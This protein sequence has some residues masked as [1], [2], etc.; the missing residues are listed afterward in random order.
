MPICTWDRAPDQ[1]AGD[2]YLESRDLE[3]W[4]S[5]LCADKIHPLHNHFIH[6]VRYVHI[7]RLV[8]VWLISL[9]RFY[10]GSFAVNVGAHVS[11]P[12]PDRRR[13]IGNTLF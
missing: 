9:E 11:D 13:V 5:P 3:R 10:K 2:V 6:A 7:Q 1:D 4:K 12:S 8:S